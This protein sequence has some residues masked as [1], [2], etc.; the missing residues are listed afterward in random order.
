MAIFDPDADANDG[1]VSV[2]ATSTTVRPINRSRKFLFL[3]NDSD[4]TIYVSLGATAVI[5]QGIRLNAAGGSVLI[6]E[7]HTGKVSA[8]CASG[9]KNLTFSENKR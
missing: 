9:S 2:L 4:E 6:D 1:K 5:N 7:K 3:C 8:I